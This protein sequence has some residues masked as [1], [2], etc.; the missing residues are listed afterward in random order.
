VK[1]DRLARKSLQLK[2]VLTGRPATGYR[3]RSVS[4]TPPRVTLEGP[5]AVIGSFTM[6]QTLPVD[7]SGMR[8]NTT[9]EPRI[10]FQGKPV[11]VLEQDIRITI[12]LQKERP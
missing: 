9:T 4:V 8:E 2:P 12:T 7:V 10:D 5:A 3:I 6:L 11:K 1:L